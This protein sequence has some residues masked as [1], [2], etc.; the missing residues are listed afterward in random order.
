MRLVDVGLVTDLV[1][2]AAVVVFVVYPLIRPES[3]HFRGKGMGVRALLY[4]A[5]TLVIPAFWLWAGR[6]EP[7]PFV[8]DAAISLPFAIDAG[9]NILGLYETIAGFDVLPHLIGGLSLTISFGLGVAPL[10]AERWVAF[11][12][13]LGFGA[14]IAIL[15]EL[16]EF[17]LMRTGA[18]GLALTYENTIQ[19]LTMGLAGAAIGALAMCTVL[20]P[21][22]G[23]PVAPF[24]WR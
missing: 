11:G 3:S 20:W 17:A 16:G 18:S 15:W 21:A 10:V 2:K 1:V 4:P 19:D 14:V 8:A 24:G 23:T 22:P 5:T 7:Y 13:V 6:P 12:L 9:A